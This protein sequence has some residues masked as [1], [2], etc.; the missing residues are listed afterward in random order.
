MRKSILLAAFACCT[1]NLNAQSTR[2]ITTDNGTNTTHDPVIM[3]INGKPVLRSEFEYSYNKNNNEGVIDRKSVEEYVPLFVNYKLKVA[4]AIDEHLDT[5]QS[6][7]NECQSDRD[8]QIRPTLISDEDVEA[9]AKEIYNISKKQVDE[10]GG[11]FNCAHIFFRIPQKMST[12]KVQQKR[13][14]ADSIHNLLNKGSSTFE[15]LAQTYSEDQTNKDKGGEL[16]W[17]QKGSFFPEFENAATAL[18]D[19]EVSNVVQSP[20]GLHIIKMLQHSEMFPYDSVRTNIINF[21]EQR[22]LREEIINNKLK[23]MAEEAGNGTTTQQIID[24]KAQELQEKDPDLKNLIQEYHDG[25]LFFE[26]SNRE[27]WEKA[28]SNEKALEQ[29]FNKNKK[30]FTWH[31][32]R[33]KGMVYHVKDKDTE[34][35]VKKSVKKLPF[36]QWKETLRTTFNKDS[37]IRI[38][39]ELGRFKEGDNTWVDNK[40]FKK[41]VTPEKNSSYPIENVFGR[42]LKA[43]EDYQDVRSQVVAQYQE[44]LEQQWVAQLKQRYTVNIDEAVV[45]TVNKH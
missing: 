45:A 32:P 11:L 35:A 5:M 39:V 31:T 1:L 36:E 37:V 43:P 3:T 12:E 21:I 28:N 9:K 13:Q 10:T 7:K 30:N 18:K 4:A 15:A 42:L 38:R 8:Q 27:V 2:Q 17:A 34:K 25:L 6:F 19:G 20:A 29:F 14:L 40:V 16:G 23:A 41:N 33:Y 24:Q 44:Y 26:I 22:N